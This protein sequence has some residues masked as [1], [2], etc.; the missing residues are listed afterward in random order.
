VR[1]IVI[2]ALLAGR[3]A[4]QVVAETG[5]LPEHWPTGG[6]NCMEMQEYYIHAYNPNFYILRQSGCTDYEKPFVY[7]IFGSDKAMLWDT[8]SRNSRI[9]E[10]VDRLIS[11]WLVENKRASIP[12]VVMH[13]HRHGDHIAGDSQF[14]DRPDTTLVKPDLASVKAF[15]GFQNWPEEART[16]DLGGR[17]LDVVA[18]PGH[19]DDSIAMYDRRTGILMTGDTVYPGRLYVSDFEAFKASIH[20]LAAFTADRP[21]AQVL[22]NHIE[23]TTTPFVDYPVRTKYQ[24]EEHELALSA[25]H[26]LELD[27][28]LQTMKEPKTVLLRDMTISVRGH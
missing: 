3:L 26:I 13:S 10:S 5:T 20:R 14:A 4:A 8:G 6:P 7:L 11:R 2:L 21:I 18:I 23:Q 17:V 28:A 24:P 15:F 1:R 22:G 9:R 19:T 27:R 12:L 25:G 16:F